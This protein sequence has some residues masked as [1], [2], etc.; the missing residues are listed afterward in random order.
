ML[1]TI[2]TLYTYNSWATNL[3]MPAIGQLTEEQY[4]ASGC[5]G[6][7]SI[8]DTLAHFLSAQRGWFSW[9]DGSKTPAELMSMRLTGEDISTPEKARAM[10]QTVEAQTQNCVAKLTEEGIR[11]VW[12][13]EFPGRSMSLPLWQL[14]IHVANHG[15]HTRA[16]IVSAIR[17]CG[18][19]PGNLD[20]LFFALEQSH[21][22]QA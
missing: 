15:T 5:S 20:L 1:E 4:N 14:L 19:T 22:P 6:H 3:L 18:G 12:T 9:F 7:G 16:Q 8:R 2:R 21:R 11:K 17:R 13:A 10:W